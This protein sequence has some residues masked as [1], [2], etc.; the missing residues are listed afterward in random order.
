M[1][2]KYLEVLQEQLN[3]LQDLHSVDFVGIVEAIINR[4]EIENV[5]Q[6]NVDD[7]VC[8]ALDSELIY[9]D[10]LWA[11]AMDFTAN[12]WDLNMDDVLMNLRDTCVE[13]LLLMAEAYEEEDDEDDEDDE[14]EEI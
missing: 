8:E 12:P 9:Y 11:L 2:E 6:Y 1:K 3:Q 5:N 4:V 10:D 7:L 13:I 14:D